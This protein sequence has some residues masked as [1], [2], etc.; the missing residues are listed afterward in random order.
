MAGVLLLAAVLLLSV[1]AQFGCSCL[2]AIFVLLVCGLLRVVQTSGAAVLGV[3][4]ATSLGCLCYCFGPFATVDSA[5]VIVFLSLLACCGPFLLAAAWIYTVCFS[6][7]FWFGIVFGTG[8]AGSL[9]LY[10]L[11]L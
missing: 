3:V 4:V 10:L 9:L 1:A 2:A 6:N 5:L 7:G 8:V 11:L